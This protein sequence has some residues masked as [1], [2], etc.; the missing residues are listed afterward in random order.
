MRPTMTSGH[1][2]VRLFS[3]AAVG[4][5]VM[6]T[7]DPRR[8]RSRRATAQ[9]KVMGLASKAGHEMNVAARDLKSRLRGAWSEARRVLKR[10]D[11]TDDRVVEERVRSKIGRVVSHPHAIDVMVWQGRVTLTGPVLASEEP[12]LVDAVRSTQGV[13]NIENRLD[14]H[15]RRDHIS[16]L[17]GGAGQPW[18]KAEWMREDWPLAL[19]LAAAIGGG[20]L[21]LYGLSRRG[22]LGAATTVVG[23][24]LLVRGALNA[25]MRRL[26]GFREN[27][28][29]IDLQRSITI[30]ALPETVFDIW[31]QYENFPRFMSHVQEVRDLSGGRAHWVVKGP[32]GGRVEWDVVLTESAPPKLLAWKSEPGSMVQHAGYAR[33][34]SIDGGCRVTVR[35]SYKPAAALGH[36]FSALFGHELKHKMESDLTRMKTFIETHGQPQALAAEDKI[37]Y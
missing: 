25:P 9:E 11:V 28:R 20:G 10:S 21:A 2:W 5:L 34:E 33:F 16:S 15:V 6:F 13:K 37:V 7:L 17:Q 29:I 35:T 32:A 18:T 14:V 24:G 19:R 31:S 27:R 1:I 8:G 23:I 30:A 22:G 26:I 4:A 3:A 36:T 12:G